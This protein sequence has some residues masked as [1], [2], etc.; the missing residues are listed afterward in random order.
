MYRQIAR[1]KRF[2]ILLIALFCAAVVGLG[3]FSSWVLEAW[4]PLVLLMLFCPLYVWWQLS[5]A[6]EHA[7]KAGCGELVL[8][9]I[10]KAELHRLPSLAK[11][12]AARL[13]ISRSWRRISFSRRRRFNSAAISSPAGGR[14]ACRT[15]ADAACAGEPCPGR[16][17]PAGAGLYPG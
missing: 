1:N 5:H 17:P 15:D 16:P 8:R 12:A 6:T 13:R 7:A 14:P 9:L 11:K 10:D 3:L 2:S 4:W